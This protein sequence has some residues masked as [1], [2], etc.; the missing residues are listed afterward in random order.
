MGGR[1]LL[2]EL[3]NVYESHIHM[4]SQDLNSGYGGEA[5][6]FPVHELDRE[7]VRK[8]WLQPR[9]VEDL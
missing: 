9:L 5:I 2:A 1:K 3:P 8:L 4:S 6:C 7:K